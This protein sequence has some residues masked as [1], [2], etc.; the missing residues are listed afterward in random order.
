MTPEDRATRRPAAYSDGPGEQRDKNAE[1]SRS[2]NAL[3]R[4][5]GPCPLSFAVRAIVT[6][7]AVDQ[8]DEVGNLIWVSFVENVQ[9]VPGDDEEPLRERIRAFPHLAVALSHYE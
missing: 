2:G 9:G 5:S 8:D 6:R 3:G 1:S 4:R 7:Y